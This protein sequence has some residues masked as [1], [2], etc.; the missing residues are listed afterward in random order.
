MV[1]HINQSKTD[2]TANVTSGPQ[3]G[4]LACSP[5]VAAWQPRINPAELIA[6][7]GDHSDPCRTDISRPLYSS[8]IINTYI[9]FLEKFYPRVDVDAVLQKSEMTR[10]EV[11]DPGH[12]FTQ[13]QT[14]RFHESLVAATGNT[15]VAREAGRYTMSTA[16]LGA[17]KQYALGSIGLASIYMKTGKLAE[18]L[19]RGARI[20][21]RKLR[22]NKVEIISRPVAGT[23]EKPY[24]CDNRVGTLEGLAKLV[25]SKYA[26][27][28]HTECLHR[29]ADCCRYVP[30]LGNN[31]RA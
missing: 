18:A 10:H 1:G 29:G 26:E 24:Q 6:L 20:T 13:H 21:T 19:S 9:E 23:H 7:P 5:T 2:R 25:T 4:R 22:S 27:V 30:D 17:A 8:R 28:E 12:W 16:R 15:R 14:D 3:G 31:D 11:E